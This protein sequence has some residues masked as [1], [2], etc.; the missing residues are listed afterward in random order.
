[1]A[2]PLY[3]TSGTPPGWFISQ[4]EFVYR[5]AGADMDAQ[6]ESAQLFVKYMAD[7]KS[8]AQALID[9]APDLL[10]GTAMQD[11][12]RVPALLADLFGNAD[13]VYYEADAVWTGVDGASLADADTVAEVG[14]LL[15]EALA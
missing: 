15:V 7:W 11:P 4:G 1:M 12:E 10:A 14:E 5:F 6:F 2:W 8:D 13:I 9:A 3:I